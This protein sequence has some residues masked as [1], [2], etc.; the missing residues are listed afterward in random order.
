[1]I[2]PDK[3]KQNTRKIIQTGYTGYPG[4]DSVWFTGYIL[5]FFPFPF[6]DSVWFLSLVIWYFGYSPSRCLKVSQVVTS[7]L[8]TKAFSWWWRRL[9]GFTFTWRH[10]C[11][12]IFIRTRL[13]KFRRALKRHSSD[14]SLLRAPLI[15]W[16]RLYIRGQRPLKLCSLFVTYPFRG[17]PFVTYPFRESLLWRTLSVTPSAV[18]TYCRIYLSWHPLPSPTPVVIFSRDTLCRHQPLS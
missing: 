5:I 2:L 10:F 16:P 1:M 3:Q 9:N 13:F 11:G 4:S 7:A 15:T 6:F 8:R 12:H 18:T 14:V 17:A